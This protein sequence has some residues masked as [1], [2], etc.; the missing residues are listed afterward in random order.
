MC[1]V[2]NLSCVIVKCEM[3]IF[4]SGSQS[5]GTSVGEVVQESGEVGA[6]PEVDKDEIDEEEE[7]V[8]DSTYQTEEEPTT[9][10]ES[11]D[12]GDCDKGQR[13]G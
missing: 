6:D 4:S 11:E 5:Q 2:R 3:P 8:N 1:F 12:D 13:K 7:G 9:E 10:T